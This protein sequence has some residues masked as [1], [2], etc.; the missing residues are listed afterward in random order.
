VKLGVIGSG[1]VVPFHLDAL[2]NVGFEISVIASR[3]GSLTTQSLAYKYRAVPVDDFYEVSSHDIDAVLIAPASGAIELPLKHF[4][5]RGIPILV[6]KPVLKNTKMFKDLGDLENQNVLVG[7]N[8]RFYSSVQAQIAINKEM[9][10]HSF[11]FK[12]PENSW[13]GDL[14]LAGRSDYLIDN[15]VHMIDLLRY[16]SGNSEMK[17]SIQVGHGEE[18]LRAI[19][20]V[21][22]GDKISG[23][24]QITFNSPGAYSI[25]FNGSGFSSKLQ[26][27]EYLRTFDSIEIIEPTTEMPIRRYRPKQSEKLFAISEFDLR[28]KPGF[29]QQS[30]A[31]AELVQGRVSSIAANLY[32]AYKAIEMVEQIK[33][34]KD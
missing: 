21:V 31:F 6:E 9:N 30:K 18:R 25:E 22:E 32:D 11:Q 8:R 29:Y 33:N 15:S 3:P 5:S 10:P 28:F 13:N 19:N 12:V 26:P 27:I 17:L 23:V 1:P 2:A 7:Y 34:V 16:L 20:V 4:I 24:L 14:D